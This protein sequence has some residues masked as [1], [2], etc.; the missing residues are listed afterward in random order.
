MSA[1]RRPALVALLGAALLAAGRVPASAGGADQPKEF[2]VLLEKVGSPADPDVVRA[3]SRHAALRDPEQATR[4]VGVLW[5]AGGVHASL[6][7]ALLAKHDAASVRAE[8]LKGIAHVGLRFHEGI[9]NVRAGL[10]DREPAVRRAACAALGKVGTAEDVASLLD[11][12]RQDDMKLV[13][14]GYR[15]LIALT[16]QRM[17]YQ[18]GRWA[19]WWAQAKEELPKR[20]ED[21]LETVT[22]GGEGQEAEVAAARHVLVQHGWIELDAVRAQVREWLRSRDARHRIEGFRV[23]TALHDGDLAD[24]VS[25]A[26]RYERNPAVWPEGLQAASALGTKTEGVR[27]P[28]PEPESPGR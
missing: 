1:L 2:D 16:T 3:L 15:G 7:L 25:S 27:A 18:A 6:A 24:E 9:E 20:I 26:F 8:A 4:L 14:E 11:V 22:K 23:A 13:Q 21:A 17:P 19:A 28:D 12:I 10:E 5:H